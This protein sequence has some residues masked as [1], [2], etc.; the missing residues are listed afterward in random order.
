VDSEKPTSLRALV[1]RLV[2]TFL[3]LV[4]VVYPLS[5]G[6]VAFYLS[7]NKVHPEPAWLGKVYGP[8]SFVMRS[9]PAVGLGVRSYVIFFVELG[10]K[11]RAKRQPKPSN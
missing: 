8:L 3:F 9:N 11:A 10:T 2:A 4:V 7:L 6:P 1:V 5:V